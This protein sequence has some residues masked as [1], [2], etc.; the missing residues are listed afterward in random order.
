MKIQYVWLMVVL[1]MKELLKSLQIMVLG[2]LFVVMVGIHV[3][4]VLCVIC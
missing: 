4:L 2:E 3:K 1:L